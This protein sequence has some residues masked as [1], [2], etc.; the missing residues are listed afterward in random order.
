MKRT[1]CHLCWKTNPNSSA[2]CFS[3]GVL[4]LSSDSWNEKSSFPGFCSRKHFC[5]NTFKTPHLSHLAANSMPILHSW[6]AN[7]AR[8]EREE[9]KI[10]PFSCLLS[11]TFNISFLKKY[12]VKKK[13]EEKKFVAE[14]WS[15]YSISIIKVEWSGLCQVSHLDGFLIITEKSI[16]FRLDRMNSY[17]YGRCQPFELEYKL[18]LFFYL[19]KW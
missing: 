4:P 16:H 17:I 19:T 13:M 2:K 15:D 14:L 8:H 6:Q 10:D 3:L 7:V 18:C 9:E 11:R 12:I 1:A 5:R